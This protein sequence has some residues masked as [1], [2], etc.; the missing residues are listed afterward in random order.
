MAT[1]VSR[2]PFA[3]ESLT[4][5]AVSADS[6]R[7]GCTWCGNFAGRQTGPRLGDRRLYLFRY[8]VETDGGRSYPD[9]KLFCSLN[10]RRAYYS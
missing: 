3:R 5:E 2:D 8:T 1:Q 10:C 4:R 6:M 7:T 9:S